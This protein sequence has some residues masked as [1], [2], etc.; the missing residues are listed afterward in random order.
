M[1]SPWLKVT[2][3]DSNYIKEKGKQTKT[4]QVVRKRKKRLRKGTDATFV[5][6]F[7]CPLFGI[8][9]LLGYVWIHIRRCGFRR[10]LSNFFFPGKLW[11]K[12]LWKE[13]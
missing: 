4:P 11:I 6:F 12:K 13:V 10:E 7:S 2:G 3:R 9:T 1:G 5:D 8:R